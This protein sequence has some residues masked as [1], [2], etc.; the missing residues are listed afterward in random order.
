M[1]T[2]TITTAARKLGISHWRVRQV[3]K[4]MGIQPVGFYRNSPLFSTAQVRQMGKRN[5][6]PG[7][8]TGERK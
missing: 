3:Y 8:R 7:P 4:A 5:K 6:K 1:R 2:E